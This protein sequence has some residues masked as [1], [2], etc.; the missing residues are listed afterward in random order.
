MMRSA[1]NLQ[2]VEAECEVRAVA[3]RF[4][5]IHLKPHLRSADDASPAIAPE[6]FKAERWPAFIFQ[7]ATGRAVG[8]QKIILVSTRVILTRS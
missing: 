2:I 4:D 8:F 7:E 5:V 1:E 6:R 3:R